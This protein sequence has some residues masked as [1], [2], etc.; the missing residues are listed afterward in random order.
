MKKKFFL[1][2]LAMIFAVG[3]AFATA[4]PS[5]E[6]AEIKYVYVN[7]TWHTI[8]V[9]CANGQAECMVRFEQDLSRTPYQVFNSEDLEDAA[10]GVGTIS[11]IPGPVPS[12]L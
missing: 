1:P 6:N 11:V 7:G 5:V 4:E 10:S 8:D 2:M 12:N 9:I 3:M